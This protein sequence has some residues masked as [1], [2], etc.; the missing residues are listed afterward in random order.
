MTTQ[1]VQLK[2][3]EKVYLAGIRTLRTRLNEEAKELN[4]LDKNIEY[5][6]AGQFGALKNLYV[7]DR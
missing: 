1:A 2:R 4:W 3:S 6:R 7:M 5:I